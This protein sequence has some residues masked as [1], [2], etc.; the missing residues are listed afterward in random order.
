M[1]NWHKKIEKIDLTKWVIT[2][3]YYYTSICQDIFG[4]YDEVW[5]N[6][7]LGDKYIKTLYFHYLEIADMY[8]KMHS[9]SEYSSFRDNKTTIE[10]TNVET[11]DKLYI[12]SKDG[13]FLIG[14]SVWSEFGHFTE[15]GIIK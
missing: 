11:R 4:E 15:F 8:F 10:I 14:K 9:G 1:E 5:H 12:T 2:K 3:F 13:R 7:P 6:R